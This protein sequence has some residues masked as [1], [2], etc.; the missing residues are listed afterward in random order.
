MASNSFHNINLLPLNLLALLNKSELP[1]Y[2]ST[3]TAPLKVE[4]PAKPP[5]KRC[6]SCRHKLALSDM[7]CRCGIRH[8]S[9][10]R[11]PEEHACTYNHAMRERTLLEAQLTPCI[12]D[13]M[14]NERI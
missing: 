7:A 13:K 3:I 9:A 4:E 10:H 11:L 5:Q 6:G 14:Q 12:S 1:T 2:A 8:C